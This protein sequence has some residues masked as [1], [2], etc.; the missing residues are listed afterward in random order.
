M[1]YREFCPYNREPNF[2]GRRGT[3]VVAGAH[4]LHVRGL[5]LGLLRK[6]WLMLCSWAML[7][8]FSDILTRFRFDKS[9]YSGSCS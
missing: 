6:G 5:L 8:G 4:D 3:A 7:S 9:Q 1:I 2:S